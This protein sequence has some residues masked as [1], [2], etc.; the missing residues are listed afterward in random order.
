MKYNLLHCGRNG[1]PGQGTKYSLMCDVNFFVE[2]DGSPYLSHSFD[3]IRIDPFY[4]GSHMGLN[5]E[6]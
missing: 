5:A 3:F 2:I 4:C 1:A 6:V